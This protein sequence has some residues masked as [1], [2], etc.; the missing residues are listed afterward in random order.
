M[1]GTTPLVSIPLFSTDVTDFEVKAVITALKNG[2]RPSGIE[3]S[4]F[5]EQFQQAYR[6]KYAV[7]VSSGSAAL[8]LCIQAAGV[9]PGDIVI[10]SPL[11][12]MAVVEAIL[13]EQAVPLFV[14]VDQSTGLINLDILHQVVHDIS[15]SNKLARRWLPRKGAEHVGSLKAIIP[16]DIL[17]QKVEIDSIANEFSGRNMVVI[18]DSRQALGINKNSHFVGTGSNCAV[19][20]FQSGFPIST[21]SGGM[22]ITDNEEMSH[23]LR[24]LRNEGC[25]P[26]HQNRLYTKL[27]YNYHMNE[28]VAALGRAQLIRLEAILAAREKVA[29]WYDLRLSG[30]PALEIPSQ[31]TGNGSQAWPT[32]VVKLDDS[33]HR[34]K[35]IEELAIQGIPSTSPL[36]AVHLQPFMVDRFGYKL[37]DFPE[38]ERSARRMLA[39]PFSS[40]MTEKQVDTVCKAIKLIL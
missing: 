37:G 32:Y 24:I 3:C 28:M 30:V 11:S 29:Q 12:D 31:F 9:T 34:H 6:T 18:E 35:V 39:L 40:M 8:H 22:I 7:S 1:A 38:A 5:E 21:G 27:G 20:S 25:D 23:V 19:Y 33:I 17:G 26:V 13:Y 2:L 15:A 4:R 36:L 16:V 10:T 14:D